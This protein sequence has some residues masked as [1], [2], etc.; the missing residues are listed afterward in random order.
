MP[1]LERHKGDRLGRWA[2]LRW[3]LALLLHQLC[4]LGQ[5]TLPNSLLQNQ[6]PH[7]LNG[8]GIYLSE[9]L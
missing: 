1:S 7:L 5:V 8:D 9:L 6:P 4:D 3:N 2:A